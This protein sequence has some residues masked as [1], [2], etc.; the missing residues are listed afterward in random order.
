MRRHGDMGPGNS[1]D[2]DDAMGGLGLKVAL[3]AIEPDQ[4]MAKK[5]QD[6]GKRALTIE[7]PWEK[8]SDVESVKSHRTGGSM[9]LTS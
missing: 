6:R 4:L 9:R 3:N 2:Y 8:R 7:K 1:P 5:M